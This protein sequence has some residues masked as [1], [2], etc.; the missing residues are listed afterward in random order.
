VRSNTFDAKPYFSAPASYH[1]NTFGGQ[2]GGPVRVPWLYNGRDRTFFEIGFEGTHYSRAGSRNILIPTAAQ[3]GES[4][5]GGPQDLLYGDFSSASTG[6]T[7]GGDCLSSD[8]LADPYPCQLYNPTFGNDAPIPNRPAY[9]GNQIPVSEMNPQSLAFIQAV[10]GTNGPMVIPGIAPTTANFQITSPTRQATY[11]YTARVDQHI[12]SRD[13]I[14]FRYSGF[15][16]NN[17]SPGTLPTLFSTTDIPAQQYGINWNHVFGPALSMQVQYGRT[18]VEDD[19][20]TAFQSRK[21]WQI[22]GCSA[23]MCNDFVGGAALL[24]TQSVSDG[25]SGGEVNSPSKNLSSIHEWSGSIMKVIG[26]HNLQAGGGWDEVNYT[27]ELR[28]GQVSFTGASTANFAGNPG[29]APGLSHSQ[30]SAQ[31][32]FGLADFLLDYPNNENKCNVLLTERP[33]GIAS[34]YVQD[35]WKMTPKLTVNYGLRYDRS[36]IPQFGTEASVGLQGSIETGDFDFNNGTY[37]LQQLPPLCSVRGDAP[38]LPSA[39][40]PPHVVVA[41]GK[42]HSRP[43]LCADSSRGCLT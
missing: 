2:M 28:Q 25:F 41:V 31:S 14:F 39:V 19:A 4:K 34:A 35:S 1:L 11:N 21:L 30:I 32:G 8:S 9:P 6:V 27:A 20:V 12:G 24:V 38:C 29:S 5:F 16:D 13:F 22:Y 40:L 37:V 3:L 7:K 15:R 33:G 17:S 43:L 36:V 18:H 10:F 26:N 23:D 42:M